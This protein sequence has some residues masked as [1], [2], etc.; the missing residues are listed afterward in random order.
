MDRKLRSSVWGDN[1]TKTVEYSLSCK[2]CL[3]SVKHAERG[4]KVASEALAPLVVPATGKQ[5]KF[6]VVRS[7]DVKHIQPRLRRREGVHW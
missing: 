7:K 2:A 1:S 4:S 5:C 3:S 6:V